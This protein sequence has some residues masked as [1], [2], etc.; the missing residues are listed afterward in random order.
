MAVVNLVRPGFDLPQERHLW[1]RGGLWLKWAG[2]QY[3]GGDWPKGGR[4]ANKASHYEAKVLG[5]CRVRSG[6]GDG[7]YWQTE[8]SQ[9]P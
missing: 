5:P 1:A 4:G 2:V 3:G 9:G 8:G 6:A 7:Y